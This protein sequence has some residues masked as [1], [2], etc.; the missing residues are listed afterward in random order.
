MEFKGSKGPWF[1][2]DGIIEDYEGREVCYIYS[3]WATKKDLYNRQLISKT[4]EM[5]ELH[6]SELKSLC[7][8]Q[9]TMYDREVST[10]IIQEI[11]RMIFYKEKLIKQA[12]EL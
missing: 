1:N 10:S 2:D 8:L 6:Q 11:E 4:P 5:L 9:Q 3:N 12:T 7:N